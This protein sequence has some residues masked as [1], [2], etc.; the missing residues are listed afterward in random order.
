MKLRDVVLEVQGT[1]LVINFTHPEPV[2]IT[3]SSC[4]VGNPGTDRNGGVNTTAMR[5]PVR[6]PANNQSI[7]NILIYYL[8]Y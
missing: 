4:G 8:D 3:V 1:S 2:C 5:S 6:N 7:E